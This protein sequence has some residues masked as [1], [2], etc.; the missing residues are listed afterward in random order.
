MN[1]T[2]CGKKR[3][4]RNAC[5]MRTGIS[6]PPQSIWTRLKR[7][8]RWEHALTTSIWTKRQNVVAVHLINFH[9]S[10]APPRSQRRKVKGGGRGEEYPSP[11]RLCVKEEKSTGAG[12]GEG[13]LRPCVG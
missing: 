6:T 5:R 3:R 11:R 4:T 1:S 12:A 13:H 2:I 9:T 8:C 10:P 7:F